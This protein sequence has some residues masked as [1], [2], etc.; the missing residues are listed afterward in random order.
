MNPLYEA[1][2][3]ALLC[4]MGHG[5]LLSDNS[6]IPA[7]RRYYAGA[8]L[9]TLGLLATLTASTGPVLVPGLS[10]FLTSLITIIFFSM[11][12]IVMICAVLTTV[13][14]RT[15]DSAFALIGFLS[16][17]SCLLMFS[18][19]WWGVLLGDLFVSLVFLT[20]I[21]TTAG[22]VGVSADKPLNRIPYPWTFGAAAIALLLL[23][24]WIM[25]GVALPKSYDLALARNYKVMGILISMIGLPAA[26]INRHIALSLYSLSIGWSGVIMVATGVTINWSVESR[27]ITLSLLTFL[28]LLQIYLDGIQ[29]RQS[30]AESKSVTWRF[31]N[32]SPAHSRVNNPSDDIY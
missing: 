29:L 18:L 5:L 30:L 25:P 26:I 27:S 32:H 31:F 28:G 9:L 7:K 22:W 20:L 24:G 10:T 1:I 13:L 21:I 19:P 14:K 16:V 6:W 4:G 12:V 2:C 23:V 17:Y 11:T 3:F 8:I 15:M